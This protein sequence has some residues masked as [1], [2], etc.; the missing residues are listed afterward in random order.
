METPQGPPDENFASDVV[1]DKYYSDAQRQHLRQ[2]KRKQ[3]GGITP[4]NGLEDVP[5][6]ELI[7]NPPQINLKLHKSTFD[8]KLDDVVETNELLMGSIVR[9]MAK[10]RLDKE[11]ED[12]VK[13]QQEEDQL[14]QA[15]RDENPLN[16]GSVQR[17]MQQ[18]NMNF[19]GAAMKK[20]N[21]EPKHKKNHSNFSEYANM[22][23]HKFNN[24]KKHSQRFQRNGMNSNNNNMNGQGMF[25]NNEQNTNKNNT[26]NNNSKNEEQDPSLRTLASIVASPHRSSFDK[27]LVN[28]V[29]TNE[30]LMGA[31][32]DDMENSRLRVYGFEKDKPRHNASTETFVPPGPDSALQQRM[33]LSF[34]K[35]L[36]T[37]TQSQDIMM[38][39]ILEDIVKK[40]DEFTGRGKK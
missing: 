37:A 33:N 38:D 17:R 27:K 2:M 35:Q 31:V 24:G 23:P 28:V 34:N 7:P 30:I 32:V 12:A 4:G 6:D 39:D 36:H 18:F 3:G 29:D 21:N 16:R 10:S 11:K 13:K 25:Q 1:A 22:P 40:E 26:K 14:L 15:Q 5:E 9:D 19:S 8:R 20:N